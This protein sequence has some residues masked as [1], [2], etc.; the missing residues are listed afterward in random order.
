MATLPS[1]EEYSLKDVEAYVKK[2][3]V[4][5]TLKE[6]IVQLC[7]AKPER[8]YSFLKDYF[9]KLEKVIFTYNNHSNHYINYTI[10]TT[11]IY[12][13]WNILFSI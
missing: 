6:C 11:I 4:Q 5:Q 7:I 2:F 8:P 13:L 12:D 1:D 3:D 9:A 10:N